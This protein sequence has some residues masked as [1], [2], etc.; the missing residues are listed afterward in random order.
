M[1]QF[2]ITHYNRGVKALVPPTA[3]YRTI[4]RRLREPLI[5]GMLCGLASALGYTGANACL[6]AVSS[7]DAVW[8]SSVK[9]FPT[10]A[11]FGPVV[12]YRLLRGRESL[13]PGRQ[14]AALIAASL[15]CQLL[16]NV[17]FQWSLG[18]VGMALAVPLTLGTMIIG[19]AIMGRVILHEPV[20]MSMACSTLILIHAVFVLSLGA[21][22]AS[23]SAMLSDADPSFWWVAT[24]VGA[25]C[26]SGVSYALLGV[27]IRY[28]VTDRISILMTMVTVTLTGVVALGAMSFVT[29]GITA[30]LATA[31]A[32]FWVM[33]LAGIFNAVAFLA[34]TKSLQLIPVVY[35]NAL[36]ATQAT[37]AAIVGILFFQEPS[38]GWLWCGVGMTVFG[39]LLMRRPPRP[40][41]VPAQK[42]ESV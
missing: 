8:V 21:G 3:R 13:P 40:Q 14:M 11:M 31:P 15:V 37:M 27:V 1:V 28:A 39:L 30:M 2:E 6:R 4:L 29:T 16:G 7:C 9:A 41:E 24:G 25:A 33:L 42:L 32:D 5:Y 23:K 12:L 38:S 36:N 34:L 19:G 10:V 20:T 22:D 35:V 18:V 26:L 17:V